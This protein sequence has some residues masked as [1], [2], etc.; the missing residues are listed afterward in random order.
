M[1]LMTLPQAEGKWA[2]TTNLIPR[3]VIG[4]ARMFEMH[5]QK[6][7]YILSLNKVTYSMSCRKSLLCAGK[8]EGRDKFHREG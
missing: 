8:V 3:E 6:L 2:R 7:K 4:R 5:R 1:V